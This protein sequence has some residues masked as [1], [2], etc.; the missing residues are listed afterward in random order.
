VFATFSKAGRKLTVEM[1]ALKRIGQPTHA[2]N[3]VA[4]LASDAGR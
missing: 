1:Q 2:A 4:F 3:V